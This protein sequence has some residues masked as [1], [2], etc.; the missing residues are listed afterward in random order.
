MRERINMKTQN[1]VLVCLF[2]LSLIATSS[3]AQSLVNT[4]HLDYL[5]ESVS[6]DKMSYGIIHIYSE[7]PGYHFVEAGGE[8]ISCVDDVARAAVFYNLYY[9]QNPST[10]IYDKMEALTRFQLMVQNENGYYNN[11]VL[12]DHS[13]NTTF[14]TSIAEPNWWSWRALWSLASLYETVKA[15][16]PLLADSML[17]SLRK[18]VKVVLPLYT[19]TKTYEEQEGFSIPLWL[20]ADC[21]ADQAAILVKGL[22]KYFSI[23][24]DSTVIPVVKSLC[25]GILQMQIEDKHSPYFGAFLSWRNSWHAWGNNQSDALLDAYNILKIEVYLT[26][27]LHE[28]SNFYPQ[29]IKNE[30]LVELSLKKEASG[31]SEIKGLKFSQ[32]AYGIRPMIFACLNAY[33]I[34]GETKYLRTSVELSGWFFGK[35]PAKK[36]IYSPETG[37]CFDG[38]I[39]EEKLNLNSG[40]ESTIEALLSLSAIESDTLGRKL[41]YEEYKLK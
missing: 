20:P 4:Q 39:D 6:K 32:I 37:R 15:Q 5:Y 29:L 41:L 9:Q 34:T 38:I 22:C 36:N 30:Y 40:A 27:A 19:K 13:V 31:I 35:N 8:G 11:F 12:K 28:L 17:Q 14:R 1:K 26:S 33:R 23:T 2:L 3:Q 7:Y 10:K 16:N 25:D 18:V 21:G 24:K